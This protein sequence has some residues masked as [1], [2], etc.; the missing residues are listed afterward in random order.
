MAFVLGMILGFVTDHFFFFFNVISSVRN[1]RC[2]S[3]IM[4]GEGGGLR[5]GPG[6]GET[7]VTS[8]LKLSVC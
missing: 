5:Q 8:V 1:L 3:S 4:P 6:E 2:D 7:G